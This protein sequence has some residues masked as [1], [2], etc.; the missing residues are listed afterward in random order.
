MSTITPALVKTLREKTGVG[1][2]DCKRALEETSGDIEAAIDW[3]RAKG[4]S[5]AAKKAGRVAA[6]GLVGL[7]VSGASAAMVEVNSETDFVARNDQFQKA[8]RLITSAALK[9]KGD[10]EKTLAASGPDG[11]TL[12]DMLVN[13]VAT[14]G[15]NM[16]VRR[17]AHVAVGQ[18]AIGSYVHNAAGE[19]LGR[20]GVLVGLESTGD[21]SK[22]KEAGRRIA[23]HIASADPAPL[24][25]TVAELD[26]KDVERERMVLTEQARES[27]KPAN[28]IE[29]M[30]EGRLRKFY[31]EVV[32]LEQAYVHD[33]DLT[34]AK[35][36]EGLAKEVGAP[37]RLTAFAMF[38]LGEGVEKEEAD[39]A[40]EVSALTKG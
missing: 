23:M 36:V 3:L 15:E 12:K 7:E 17:A 11:A 19:G 9:A 16:T 18:G 6:E 32:L 14:I 33:P 25:V 20:I 8:V 28:V 2:M 4:L 34:V 38:K 30:I 39:F 37:V 26:P 1:M 27:G 35:Y 22:L 21:A 40:A 5:K 13:L 29:K 24:A 31:Q 10:V